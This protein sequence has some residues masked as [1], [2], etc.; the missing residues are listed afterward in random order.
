MYFTKQDL[1]SIKI[2]K[3]KKKWFHGAFANNFD[4]RPGRT[5]RNL[6]FNKDQFEEG[7]WPAILLSSM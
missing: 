2:S 6:H 3:K 7:T 4:L 5:F 1:I